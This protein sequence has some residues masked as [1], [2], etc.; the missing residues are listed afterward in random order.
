METHTPH[1]HHSTGKKV[2]QYFY[3]FLML[4]LAITLGFFVEN[5]REHYVEEKRAGEYAKSLLSDLVSDTSEIS[6]ANHQANFL[7]LSIDSL[8]SMSLN[9]NSSNEAP[10]SF[11]YYSRC[12]SRAFTVDWAKSTI[13]QLVQSGNLRYFKNKKLVELV[14][15]YFFFQ[16]VIKI[17]NESDVLR[18]DKI[19][20][21]QNCILQSRFYSKFSDLDIVEEEY[22]HQPSP[23]IDTLLTKMLPLQPEGRKRMDEYINQLSDRKSSMRRNINH[24]YPSAFEI[25]LEVMKLLKTE[26]HLE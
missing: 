26:Y 19:C 23:L 1:I 20:E 21:V 2:S 9:I 11:Y 5:Q 15:T 10:A 7:I 22:G 3:E 18:R 6:L 4:F 14:N 12:I 8:T 24:F 16:D 25:N 17:K 13:Y